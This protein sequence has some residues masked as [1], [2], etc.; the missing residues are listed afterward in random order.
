VRKK[1]LQLYSGKH[2]QL[3]D[4]HTGP[5]FARL[6]HAMRHAAI[7][8]HSHDHGHCCRLLVQSGNMWQSVT[9]PSSPPIRIHTPQL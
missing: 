3:C 6:G 5:P 7:R 4:G 2:Q 8:D 9:G 1:M